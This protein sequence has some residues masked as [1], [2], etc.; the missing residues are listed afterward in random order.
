MTGF[1][2]ALL[3]V[4]IL[5][6]AASF[7]VTEKLSSSDISIIERMSDKEVNIIIDKR[8]KAATDKIDDTIK[9]RM[10]EGL[11]QFERRA[12][13]IVTEEIYSI[14]EHGESVRQSMDDT[15]KSVN[16]ANQNINFMF[17]QLSE[18]Q[19]AL[20]DLEREAQTLESQLRNMKVNVEESISELE[21][22]QAID[23]IMSDSNPTADLSSAGSETSDEALSSEADDIIAALSSIGASDNNV[24]GDEAK[25]S[26]DEIIDDVLNAAIEAQ[27]QENLNP[28]EP[29]DNINSKILA[30]HKE[31]FSDIDIAKNL[32]KG[33]GE[34]K[35]VLGLFE[36]DE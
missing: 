12:D 23:D 28:I 4:G 19:D 27:A 36:E 14:S 34:I 30:M 15:L 11:G 29:S 22:K 33:V 31:G 26:D 16:L 35:L 10:D 21:K 18:K 2:I 3:V 20:T 9:Q 1:E 5:F 6:F 8:I 25:K 32:G 13:K 7:F 24:A 17:E